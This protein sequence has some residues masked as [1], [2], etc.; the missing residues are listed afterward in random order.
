MDRDFEELIS[1][2]NIKEDQREEIVEDMDNVR[3][4]WHSLNKNKD[5]KKN[6]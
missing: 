2:K 3:D 4:L 5:T 6:R 1:D